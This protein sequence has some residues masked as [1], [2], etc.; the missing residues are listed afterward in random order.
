MN[1]NF[2]LIN[3]AFHIH[4]SFRKID[5]QVYRYVSINKTS[6]NSQCDSLNETGLSP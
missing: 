4:Y 1:S 3:Y 6:K 2:P 5:I